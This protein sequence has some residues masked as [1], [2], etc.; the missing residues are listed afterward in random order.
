MWPLLFLLLLVGII[1]CSVKSIPSQSRSSQ[2]LRHIQS[3]RLTHGEIPP[4]PPQQL[5]VRPRLHDPAFPKH[6]NYIRILDRR[7]PMR[8]RDRGPSLRRPLQR[9][10]HYSLRLRIQRRGGFVQ[11]QEPRFPDQGAGDG[12]ALFLAAGELE[13]AGAAA[14]AEAFGER[15]DEVPGV[16]LLAGVDDLVFCGGRL[17][18]HVV[19]AEGDVVAHGA[20]EEGRFLLHEG[21]LVAVDARGESRHGL[22]SDGDGAGSR[23]VEAFEEG[24]HG[25]LAAA[26]GAYEGGELAGL[27]GHA[28]VFEDEGFALSVM[29]VDVVENDSSVAV[30]GRVVFVLVVHLHS[31]FQAAQPKEVIRGPGGFAYGWAS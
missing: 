22:V 23:V 26:R 10:L 24:H 29:K 21:N 28:E 11:E 13:A 17:V 2:I 3:L 6:K 16:G 8:Y 27:D 9:R 20:G 7:Q 30:V 4:P 14:R 18:L 19:D 31:W 5:L 15:L 25:R 1:K 12:D